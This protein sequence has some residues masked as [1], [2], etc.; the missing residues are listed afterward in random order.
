MG[1]DLKP[2]QRRDVL[3]FICKAFTEGSCDTYRM[4]LSEKITSRN[5]W[6]VT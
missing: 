3:P 5:T 6:K 2:E 4:E 1:S